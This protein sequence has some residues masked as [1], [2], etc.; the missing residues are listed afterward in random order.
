MGAPA[1]EF[2][3]GV[4]DHANDHKTSQA[5][6]EA[7]DAR[8]TCALAT[9]NDRLQGTV[10]VNGEN[11]P[12]DVLH[13]LNLMYAMSMIESSSYEEEITNARTCE[14]KVP[15]SYMPGLIAAIERW[16]RYIT[17]GEVT[18]L[19]EPGKATYESLVDSKLNPAEIKTKLNKISVPGA[20]DIE[21]G[22]LKIEPVGASVF[23]FAER[24]SNNKIAEIITLT[25]A[26]EAQSVGNGLAYVRLNLNGEVISGYVDNNAI[27]VYLDAVEVTA[28]RINKEPRNTVMRNAGKLLKEAD[29]KSEEI[30]VLTRNDHVFFKGEPYPGWAELELSDG[31][32]GYALIENVALRTPMPDPGAKLFRIESGTRLEHIIKDEYGQGQKDDQRRY[33]ANVILQVNNPENS[34][35]GDMAIYVE[36]GDTYAHRQGVNY[37]DIV[38]RAGFD[39]WLPGKSFADSLKGQISSGSRWELVSGVKRAAIDSVDEWWPKGLG[40]TLDAGIGLTFGAPS[41]DVN[42]GM[43]FYRK[44][45]DHLV[46][47]KRAQ[48]AAGAEVGVGAGFFLGKKPQDKGSFGAGASATANAEAKGTLYGLLEYEFPF[49]EDNAVIS[50]LATITNQEGSAPMLVASFLDSLGYMQVN[51]MDYITKAKVAIGARAEANAGAFGGVRM[52][53]GR[54]YGETWDQRDRA[55]ADQAGAPVRNPFKP[56][57]FLASFLQIGADAQLAL[58]GRFG[59]EYG[60]ENH[61]NPQTDTYEPKKESATF[62]IEGSALANLNINLPMIP[63]PTLGLEQGVGV[64]ITTAIDHTAADPSWSSPEVSLV[65]MSGELDYYAGPAS[66]IEMDG[67]EALKAGGEALRNLS[68]T[69]DTFKD[70]VKSTKITKRMALS[71][72]ILSTPF[73]RA[74][75]NQRRFEAFLSSEA[76]RRYGLSIEGYLTL[77]FHLNNLTDSLIDR[78]I[79]T[80]RPIAESNQTVYQKGIELLQHM[81]SGATSA[82]EEVNESDVEGLITEIFGK[83]KVVDGSIYLSLSG[84]IAGGASA[85]VGAKLKLDGHL[86]AGVTFE[87]DILSVVQNIANDQFVRDTLSNITSAASITELMRRIMRQPD[88]LGDFL[89]DILPN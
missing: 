79:E 54:N 33:Y 60:R 35:S 5:E 16:Q 39:I 84:G 27:R 31:S 43:Y 81:V 65:A 1:K 9:A 53:G 29:R 25:E 57:E 61:R 40:L 64:K 74:L 67:G 7:R 12:G 62:F 66:E 14:T 48:L 11:E 10:G 56:K 42:L 87:Q 21:K 32:R 46:V 89:N 20:E 44:D 22:G 50:A 76:Y 38:Y 73:Q 23:V 82:M 8:N 26:F 2:E 78:V 37:Q 80:V 58:E 30:K 88:G 59:V 34:T 3:S 55:P 49:K 71:A 19:L 24:E 85:G 41:G 15:E 69:R 28:T 52:S 72:G 83:D 51:P 18:R 47:Q 4:T 45:D 77:T 13:A 63:L 6:K 70:L 36:G 86:I 75:R 17:E 68:L